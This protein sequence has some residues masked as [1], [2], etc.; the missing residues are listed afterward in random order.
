[1]Q[2]GNRNSQQQ[3]SANQAPRTN[4]LI[5][6]K[7]MEY[8]YKNSLTKELRLFTYFKIESD[9]KFK[10]NNEKKILADLGIRN[11]RTLRE[12]INSLVR[13][14][15]VGWDKEYDVLH[16]RS[17]ERAQLETKTPGALAA[18]LCPES[19]KSLNEFK[20]WITGALVKFTYKKK[21]YRTGRVTKG[22]NSEFRVVTKPSLSYVPKKLDKGLSVRYFGATVGVSKSKAQR[23]LKL[24]EANKTISREKRVIP[25]EIYENGNIVFQ[26]NKSDLSIVYHDFPT[27]FGR[28]TMKHARH[29]GS[30]PHIRIADKLYSTVEVRKRRKFSS[31][32]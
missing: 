1:M 3:I 2:S 13:M 12:Q 10:L 15:F 7:L 28:V 9:G 6:L 21:G 8:C 16:I 32:K 30:V 27:L 29:V 18:K 26:P 23:D 14:N 11:K 31:C 22:N 5:P 20:S 25:L 17:F 19:L 24:A 4:L